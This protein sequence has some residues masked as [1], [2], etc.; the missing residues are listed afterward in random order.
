MLFRSSEFS[1]GTVLDAYYCHLWNNPRTYHTG[2]GGYAPYWKAVAVVDDGRMDYDR[3]RALPLHEER[4]PILPDARR[5]RAE[6]A[7]EDPGFI[8]L[9]RRAVVA[10]DADALT[11]GPGVGK[12]VAQRV[13]LDLRD[14]LGGEG[15]EIVASNPAAFATRVSSEIVKWRKVIQDAGI[16]PE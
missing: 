11:V 12:K 4:V 8:A 10:G 7:L 9:L 3:S 1:G 14:K 15:A 6:P 16:K 2:L 13:V 5:L